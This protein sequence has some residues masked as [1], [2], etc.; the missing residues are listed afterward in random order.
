M[1]KTASK[2][3]HTHVN[4]QNLAQ[5]FQMMGIETAAQVTLYGR[6]RQSVDLGLDS[7]ALRKLGLHSVFNTGIGLNQ[8][9]QEVTFVYDHLN[10]N[11]IQELTKL[12]PGLNAIGEHA[13]GID[14]Y[15]QQGYALEPYLD[16]TT[17]EFGVAL[18]PTDQNTAVV[19]TTSWGVDATTEQ[20]EGGV[21]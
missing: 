9:E 17:H 5:A 12:L 8:T 15:L 14:A 3:L 13:A 19:Q 6:R 10:E 7:D 20:T 11:A 1:S 4:I 16:P 18:V 2:R 21:W